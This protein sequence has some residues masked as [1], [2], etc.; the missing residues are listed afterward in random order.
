M[1]RY[2]VLL[3]SVASL[4]VWGCAST[5]ASQPPAQ[6]PATPT[7]APKMP[8]V[9]TAFPQP[10]PNPA[11]SVGETSKTRFREAIFTA[12]NIVAPP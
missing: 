9:P 6:V 11:G 8:V 10:A 5:P 1:K 7:A 3:F 12:W 2:L 4:L